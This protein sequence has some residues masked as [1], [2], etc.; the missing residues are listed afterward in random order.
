[1]MHTST[2]YPPGVSRKSR[3]LNIRYTLKM[4]SP[5]LVLAVVILLCVPLLLVRK[6]TFYFVRH[7][8][9]LLNAQHIKQ[10]PEGALSPKGREQAERVGQY[11]HA[12]KIDRIISSTYER[13][14]ETTAIINTVLKVP[15][16]YSSL[17]T[18]RKSPSEVLGKSTK[19]PLVISI[20]D[21]TELSY[22]ED[23][24]RYSDEENFVD[25]S[26]RARVALNLLAHQGAANTCVVTH[27][28]FL[29]MLIAY[30]LYREHLH[31]GQFATLSFFN[32]SDNAGITI[33]EYRPWQMFNQ[34]RGWSVVAYNEHPNIEA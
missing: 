9:T 7:G 10:G 27:R 13:A 5:V 3:G 30:M 6:R 2:I 24:Y 28:A 29:K 8:E 12:Y 1:M 14:K 15:V 4:P 17:F 22:H 16:V 21:K 11:L 25:L 32:Y 20:I 31:A 23:D 33:C 34:T 18:E 26:R 19:D